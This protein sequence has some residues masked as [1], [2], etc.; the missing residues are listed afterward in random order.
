MDYLNLIKSWAAK[1]G[2]EG[3]LGLVGG[4]VLLILGF[5]LFAGISI[6]F[7]V[8]KNWDML[9]VWVL[10]L[11]NKVKEVVEETKK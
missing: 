8:S 7:F 9:K 11:L 1:T 5:K 2:I 3:F 4:F 6:G 10:E